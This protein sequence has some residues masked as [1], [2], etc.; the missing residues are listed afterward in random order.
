MMLKMLPL[1]I[2]PHYATRWL[3][4]IILRLR[5]T[6][7]DDDDYVAIAVTLLL[8]FTSAR[9]HTPLIID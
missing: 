9:R 8:L 5:V 2:T 3:H 7:R 6:L 1:R 4:M